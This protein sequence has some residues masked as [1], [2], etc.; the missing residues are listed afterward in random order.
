MDP[1]LKVN[2]IKDCC[3]DVSF[4]GVWDWVI[5]FNDPFTLHKAQPT[6]LFSQAS[7]IF[8]AVATLSHALKNGGR[9]P[10]LWFGTVLHGLVLEIICYLQPNVDNFW[11]S[12]TPVILFGRRLPLHIVFLYPCFL[13]QAMAAAANMRLS[14]WAE[15][16]AVGA[17]VVLIDMPY[18]IASVKFVHWT[19]HDTD[20]NIGDRHYWVPW[21]S[22]FF[23][24]TFAASFIFWFNRSMGH[25]AMHDKWS[26]NSFMIEVKRML[27][28][29]LLGAPGGVLVFIL[30]YHPLH[31]IAGIHTEV[32]FFIMFSIVMLIIWT[33]DRC[34]KSVLRSRTII[35][36]ALL[37]HYLVFLSMV[38]VGN[39]ENEVSTG[40]HEPTGPCNETAP[41]QTALGMVLEKKKYLCVDDYDEGYFDFSCTGTGPPEGIKRW[42]T[43]CG[44][45]FAN[46]A[47]YIS[48]IA[49]ISTVAA[50]FFY[51]VHFN[52]NSVS[53]DLK[54]KKIS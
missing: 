36:V 51:S 9:W 15:P 18:D 10:Y 46:R 2:C 33:N 17:I 22:Y 26:A 42:Y 27:V 19:W 50:G 1:S 16:W 41:L 35:V 40:L 47:E 44:T 21:N 32:T 24:C 49:T 12:Q 14:W 54:I 6:Y 37:V 38:I 20:P 3:E 4:Q 8:G 34:P 39:P 53:D 11:H 5:K 13:Y 7:F 25:V 48:I 29:S 23:H 52:V 31:D 43:I 30:I 45:A 28:A